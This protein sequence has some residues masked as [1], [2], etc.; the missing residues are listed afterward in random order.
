VTGP[1]VGR[2]RDALEIWTLPVLGVAV[3]L[4][5]W[6]LTTVLFDIRSFILPSPLVVGEVLQEQLPYLLDMTRVTFLESVAGFGLA[7]AVGIPLAVAMA[8]SRILSRT[9]DPLLVAVN[10][11]PKVAVAPIFVIWMGFGPA[12]KVVMVLVVC[13]FPIVISTATG[14]RNTP[15]ELVE[16]AHS[17]NAG[18]GRTMWK[19]RFPQALPQIF[20]GLKTAVALA[21]IGAVIG[22]FVGADAGLGYIVVQSQASANTALAFASIT[23]LAALSI[24][25]FY[26]VVAAERWLVPWPEEHR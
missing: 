5:G 1:P 20:V 13:F 24:V 4:V 6:W 2:T 11:V 25:M 10:A 7:I 23:L 26:L 19:I 22:E 18:W 9:I 21:V 3:F 17:L 8:G 12:P 16:L 14:L 15:A